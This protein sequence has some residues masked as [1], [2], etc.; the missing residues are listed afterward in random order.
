MRQFFLRQAM[1]H[2]GLVFGFVLT[3]HQMK[4]SVPLFNPSI[5]SGRQKVPIRNLLTFEFKMFA[6]HQIK[7]DLLITQHTGVGRH[8]PLISGDKVVDDLLG[9][10]DHAIDGIIRDPHVSTLLRTTVN[11][12]R[13][14]TTRLGPMTMRHANHGF[15]ML[16]QQTRRDGRVHPATQSH[17]DRNVRV[18][19]GERKIQRFG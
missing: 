10:L 17:I 4:T 19:S 5:M 7:A 15:E 1:Q 6:Q 2:V 12:L 13:G 16:L 11:A 3:F 9:K 18:M 14:T 8:A